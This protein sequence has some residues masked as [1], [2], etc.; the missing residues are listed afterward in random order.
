M[1]EGPAWATYLIGSLSLVSTHTVDLYLVQSG[2]RALRNNQLW[3]VCVWGVGEGDCLGFKH[4]CF[5]GCFDVN[6]PLPLVSTLSGSI[7]PIAY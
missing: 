4:P 1:V 7:L 5:A 6:S 2:R 3:L